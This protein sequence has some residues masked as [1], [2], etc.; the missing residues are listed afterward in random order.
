MAAVSLGQV[1]RGIDRTRT[2]GNAQPDGLYDLVNAY[3][4]PARTVK[5]RPGFKRIGTV[6]SGGNI[7]DG[8]AWTARGIAS[9]GGRIVYFST[10]TQSTEGV[11]TLRYPATAID[12]ESAWSLYRVRP[13]GVFLGRL[14]AIAEWIDGG[15]ARRFVHY[16]LQNPPIWTSSTAKNVGDRVRVSP[17]N[18]FYYAINTLPEYPAW[19]PNTEYE[20][21]DNVQPSVFNGYRYELVENVDTPLISGDTEPAFK[22]TLKLPGRRVTESRS[23]TAVSANPPPANPP[24]PPQTPPPGPGGDLREEYQI[25]YGDV[26]AQRNRPRTMLF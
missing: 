4:T 20:L 15:G 5:K 13:I 17:D 7:F 14:Y 9:F 12:P 8:T 24:E 10:K 2:R 6:P 21:G 3:V 16:W 25:R 19:R 1:V 22:P 26:F 11:F 18:G 23:I